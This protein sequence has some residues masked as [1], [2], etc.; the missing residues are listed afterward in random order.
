MLS[1]LAGFIPVSS[2]TDKGLGVEYR[3]SLLY[4]DSV[5][6]TEVKDSDMSAILN[7]HTPEGR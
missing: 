3:V 5:S 2:S 1:V 7:C 4:C 6:T